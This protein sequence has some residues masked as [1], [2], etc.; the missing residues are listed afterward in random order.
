MSTQPAAGVFVA[1]DVGCAVSVTA[2]VVSVGV[3]TVG[4]GVAVIP[5]VSPIVIFT[6]PEGSIPSY[7]NFLPS[8]L[9]DG[10]ISL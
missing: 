10:L 3:I 4:V 2:G 6:I 5:A 7:E 9:N 1:V 8:R